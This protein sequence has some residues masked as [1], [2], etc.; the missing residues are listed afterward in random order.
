MTKFSY[1]LNE[2]I[3]QEKMF[4]YVKSQK[5]EN[6]KNRDKN[7]QKVDHPKKITEQNNQVIRKITK[8]DTKCPQK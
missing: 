2:N 4:V 7:N 3:Y 5:T 6:A 1:S 8:D